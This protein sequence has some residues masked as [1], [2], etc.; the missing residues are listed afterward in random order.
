MMASLIYLTQRGYIQIFVNLLV[1]FKQRSTLMI[2]PTSPSQI[3]LSSDGVLGSGVSPGAIPS[4]L[5]Y[6]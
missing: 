6:V 4:L 1:L 5:C 3:M 2:L